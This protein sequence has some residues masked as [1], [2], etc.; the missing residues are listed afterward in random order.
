M[1]ISLHTLSVEQTLLFSIVPTT[2]TRAGFMGL[3]VGTSYTDV[4]SI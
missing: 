2:V 3:V 4:V 1:L